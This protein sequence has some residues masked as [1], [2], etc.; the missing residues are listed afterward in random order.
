MDMHPQGGA[1]TS[2]LFKLA[3]SF[4]LFEKKASSF[5][6]HKIQVQSAI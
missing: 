6:T 5:G 3:I 4:L 2:F 1:F